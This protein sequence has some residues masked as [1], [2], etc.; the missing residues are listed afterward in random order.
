HRLARPEG[1]G[2][3]RKRELAATHRGRA[4]AGAP[5]PALG[6][7]HLQGAGRGGRQGFAERHLHRAG[8]RRR[9]GVGRRRDGR[10][11]GRG[12]LAQ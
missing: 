6:A 2:A 5:P 9:H 10:D 3:G 7:E 1:V 4:G 11:G 12:R 8:G